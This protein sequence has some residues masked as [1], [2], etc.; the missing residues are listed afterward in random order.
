LGTEYRYKQMVATERAKTRLDE[1]E[2]EFE[3]IFG[4]IH[5]GQM[6]SYRVE[7]ADILLLTTGSCS[8]TAMVAV[9]R[10]R[11]AGI[12]VGMVRIRMFR[13]FPRERL[14]VTVKNAK[15]AAVID[16]NVCFGWNCGNLFMEAKAAL[17]GAGFNVPLVNFICGLCGADITI[18]QLERSIDLTSQALQRGIDKEVIWLDLE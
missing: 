1:I 8:G 11:A 17:Y 12:K 2:K 15:V 18:E 13:P 10:Q 16:R 5:G 7:D 4:R 14:A 3:S 9:D 6:E